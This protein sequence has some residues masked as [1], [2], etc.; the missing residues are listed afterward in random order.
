MKKTIFASN[1][2]SDGIGDFAHLLDLLR[3]KACLKSNS[4]DSPDSIAIV[5][6]VYDITH[7]QRLDLWK[8]QL[9]KL[10]VT[11]FYFYCSLGPSLD[12]L[13]K[14]DLDTLG[15][16][17]DY[18]IEISAD[19]PSL[20]HHSPVPYLF[21][22]EHYVSQHPVL[23]DPQ[24]KPE[25]QEYYMALGE[26]AYGR[27]THSI[28]IS[29]ENRSNPAQQLATMLNKT[30]NSEIKKTLLDTDSVISPDIAENF[31]N[32]N[33]FIPCYFQ[34]NEFGFVHAIN[35]VVE[36]SLSSTFKSI[37][38]Y[39]NSADTK[40]LKSMVDKSYLNPKIDSIL[41]KTKT[42]TEKFQL[43]PKADLLI[44]IIMGFKINSDEDYDVLFHVAPYFA[45]CSGDKT[46]EK[47]IANGLI[48]LFTPHFPHKTGF[49]RN[50]SAFNHLFSFIEK[51]AFLNLW[52]ELPSII[53]KSGLRNLEYL[54]KEDFKA[55][56]LIYTKNITL[57]SL[58]STLTAELQEF[59][60]NKYFEALR[61]LGSELN[62]T[63][64]KEWLELCSLIKSKYNLHTQLPL[65]F[66]DFLNNVALLKA[67]SENIDAKEKTKFKF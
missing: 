64:F 33:L 67:S 32:K 19:T 50:L 31:L 45:G 39:I 59:A 61:A 42:G 27:S 14:K 62:E 34:H 40:L 13:I 1:I 52:L 46:F 47:T 51:F 23:S 65:I 57:L 55:L 63:F 17:L 60:R 2:K 41:V 9:K 66:K 16:S 20:K 4:P 36:S 12:A 22:K 35:T 37:V 26:Q 54:K 25:N 44:T 11:E 48:P 21:I 15:T 56:E 38:F 29:S 18:I 24:E 43:N 6:L 5:F 49:I 7:E 30:A 10:G 3:N 58:S 28:F 8:E 53:R